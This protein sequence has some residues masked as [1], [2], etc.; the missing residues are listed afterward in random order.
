MKRCVITG[1]GVICSI[2]NNLNEVWN[3]AVKGVCGIQEIKSFNTEN[4]TS[5]LG[6]EVKSFKPTFK[7]SEKFSRRM[8]RVSLLCIEAASEALTNAK[9]DNQINNIGVVI[10]SC[11][12]GVL[13]AEKFQRQLLKDYKKINP[14]DILRMPINTIAGNVAWYFSIHG[15]VA[16]I[17][18]ACA[19]GSM[20]IGYAC[21]LIRL[22]LVDI[23][24]AGGTDTIASLPFSGFNSLQ[25]LDNLSCSPFSRSKGLSLGEGAGVLIVESL[26]NALKRQANIYCEIVG[27]G[28]TSDAYHITA[29]RI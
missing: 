25:A 28:N 7:K 19:A 20:S 17:V 4:C 22:G 10:G 6:A 26:E 24:I 27:V 18:N 21:D 5:S 12:G 15:P 8:D 23:V 3:N 14:I 1:L 11:T 2:G 13:S 16:N 29:P 9:I